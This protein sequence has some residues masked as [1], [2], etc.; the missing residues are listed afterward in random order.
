[1]IGSIIEVYELIDQ[2][3]GYQLRWYFYFPNQDN[4][5]LLDDYPAEKIDIFISPIPKIIPPQDLHKID[6]H[7]FAVSM[8]A[9]IH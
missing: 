6:T 8:H 3:Q 4:K 7:I 5:Q 2:Q 9:Y 1:M